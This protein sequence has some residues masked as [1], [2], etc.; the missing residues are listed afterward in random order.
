MSDEGVFE[1]PSPPKSAHQIAVGIDFVDLPNPGLQPVPSFDRSSIGPGEYQAWLDNGL[2]YLVIHANPEQGS[3][4]AMEF[5][6]GYLSVKTTTGHVL[7]VPTAQL[8]AVN[9][10]N[11][12]KSKA[13]HSEGLLILTVPL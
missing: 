4:N 9:R 6:D 11:I 3:C 10:A 2:L 13:Y 12:K 1:I 5:V 8:G 7:K